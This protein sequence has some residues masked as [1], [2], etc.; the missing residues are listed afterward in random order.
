LKKE[1][2]KGIE[3]ERMQKKEKN[4][5]VRQKMVKIETRHKKSERKAK[6]LEG[7][8]QGRKNVER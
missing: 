1:R 3:K 7:G 4:V 2:Y 8:K 6:G 5:M